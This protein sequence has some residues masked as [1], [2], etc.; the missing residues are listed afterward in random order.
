MKDEQ[1]V[2]KVNRF[3]ISF[4]RSGRWPVASGQC[5]VVGGR[6]ARSQQSAVGSQ[7]LFQ[8]AVIVN[9]AHK[10]YAN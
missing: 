3:T 1:K 7:M 6:G 8:V 4:M 2:A 9:W 10:L 5:L